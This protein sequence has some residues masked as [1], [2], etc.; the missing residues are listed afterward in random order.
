MLHHLHLL[1]T[2]WIL[3]DFHDLRLCICIWVFGYLYLCIR[4]MR[5]HVLTNRNRLGTFETIQFWQLGIWIH[6]NH[7]DLTIK[8]RH[9][10]AFA[11]LA[12]FYNGHMLK[13][14]MLCSFKRYKSLFPSK[15][16]LKL[17]IQILMNHLLNLPWPI[18]IQRQFVPKRFRDFFKRTSRLFLSLL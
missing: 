4:V 5:K 11:I 14:H 12:M 17:C 8:E 9:L 16:Y 1:Y 18:E 15:D 7:C 13:G 2:H 3:I 10:T 6:D